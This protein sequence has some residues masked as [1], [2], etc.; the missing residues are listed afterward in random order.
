MAYIG[1]LLQHLDLRLRHRR[2]FL[3]DH[4]QLILA[5]QTVVVGDVLCVLAGSEGPFI[6]RLC[7]EQFKLVSEAYVYG[8]M[9]GEVVNGRRQLEV[10]FQLI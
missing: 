10:A 9:D 3:S 8:I 2:D 6:L 1:A 5:G 7:G 4:D